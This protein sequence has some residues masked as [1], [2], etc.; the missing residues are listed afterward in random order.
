[1][2]YTV[3]A[4]TY[5]LRVIDP[6][7]AQALYPKL[8]ASQLSE[9][10]TAW[11]YNYPYITNY[12]VFDKSAAN[13]P[14]EA[15]LIYGAPST[16]GLHTPQDAYDLAK[17]DGYYNEFYVGAVGA[18][19][20]QNQYTFAA[21]ETLI[22]AVPDYDLSDNGGGV[23]VLISPEQVSAVPAPASFTLLF[24]GLVSL[25]GYGCWRRPR[26]NGMRWEKTE[27][28]ALCGNPV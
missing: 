10:Y 26:R 20:L 2:K 14:S 8:T 19:P 22:F 27:S 11:T 7:D 28:E 25:A 13:N 4:G 24:V 5:N 3:Q 21:P 16:A 6:T 15:Q 23:S 9:V 12:L 18:S 1:M 17:T